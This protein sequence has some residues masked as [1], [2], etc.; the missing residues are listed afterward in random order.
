MD[1]LAFYPAAKLAQM[2]RAGEVSSKELLELYLAR[3]EKLNSRINAVVT[4]DAERACSQARQADEL[5][6]KGEPLG[7]L[8][9]VPVTIKDAFETAGL[10]TTCGSSRL[11]DYIPAVNARA[12]RARRRI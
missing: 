2:I 6:S 3:I 5:L 4:L 8:H 7:P 1:E 11:K 9:G 12:Q 10:L